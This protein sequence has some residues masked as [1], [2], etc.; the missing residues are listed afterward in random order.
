VL[1]IAA[2]C[3]QAMEHA[4]K[5]GLVHGNVNPEAIVLVAGGSPK[6]R[7]FGADRDDAQSEE[8]YRSP[9]QR[10][11]R[12]TDVRSDI[13]SLGALLYYLLTGRHPFADP[14]PARVIDGVVV[15]A[16]HPLAEVNRRLAPEVVAL[17]E[18]MMAFDPD[19]RFATASEFSEAVE[20]TRQQRD[21]R[22][23]IRPAR[24]ARPGRPRPRAGRVRRRRRR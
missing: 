13:Y 11:G 16:P 24:P 9:E 2:A 1:E 3:A 5:R 18:R 20:S 15:E 12:A 8:D 6:L 22:P 21:S 23:A 7:G 17:V 4:S 14:P 19:D 10:V